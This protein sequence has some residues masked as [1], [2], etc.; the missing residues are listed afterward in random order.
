MQADKLTGRQANGR[1]GKDTKEDRAK[2]GD[3]GRQKTGRN[4]LS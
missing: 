4:N 3:A 1:G 2:K